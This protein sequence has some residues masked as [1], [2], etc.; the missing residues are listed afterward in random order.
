MRKK[1]NK[2]G[3]SAIIATVILI[4][5]VVFIGGLV[6]VIVN[7]IVSRGMEEAGSC[8]GI[9][10][11]VKLDPEWTCYNYTSNETLFKIDIGDINVD[12]VFVGITV[13]G[14]STSFK[15][16]KSESQVRGLSMYPDRNPNVRLPDKGGGFTYIA[17]MTQL[18]FENVIPSSIQISPIIGK[19]TCEAS[20]TI[21][22]ISHCR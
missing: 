11:K 16:L 14:S 5:L 7:N 17:N 2:K 13:Q 3:V 19:Q 9:F 20:S 12:Q 4:A 1:L 6:W 8:F 18:G 22:D 21:S 15:I 10:D